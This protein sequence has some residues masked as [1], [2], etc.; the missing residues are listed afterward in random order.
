M[1][2]ETTEDKDSPTPAPIR[3]PG[4]S[5]FL[6]PAGQRIA[7]DS[8]AAISAASFLSRDKICGKI[9]VSVSASS[10][11]TS[12]VKKVVAAA[13]EIAVTAVQNGFKHSET[14]N[15]E[16]KPKR[17]RGRPK[18]DER[19]SLPGWSK[20]AFGIDCVKLLGHAKLRGPDT[21]AKA[22]FKLV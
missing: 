14:E 8:D 1:I 12:P 4:P 6:V 10:P 22:S 19:K 11:T 21:W 16:P 7:E 2:P 20:C 5:R 13:A 17:G 15:E 3:R 9:R 18:K